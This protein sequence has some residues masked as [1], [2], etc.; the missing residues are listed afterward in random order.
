MKTNFTKSNN[1]SW[2]VVYTRSRC[3]KKV[4][5]LL[6]NQKIQSFCPT[7]KTKR[8]WVDRTKTV[9]LPLFGSYL[10]VNA[11]PK[12]QL[13][14]RQTFGVVNFV[15]HCGKPV[16]IDEAEIQRIKYLV[17][18]YDHDVEAVPI[19]RIKIGDDL[20]IENGL[21]LDWQGE[22]IKINGKSVVMFMKEL[23]CALVVNTL[24]TMLRMA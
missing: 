5:M 23:N 12:E 9:E 1:S 11:N 15:N 18:L 3:E 2:M 7:I 24:Y 6:Q 16:R 19:P 10:F 8:R 21:L 20:K 22:V 4:D 13:L 17:D 14:V